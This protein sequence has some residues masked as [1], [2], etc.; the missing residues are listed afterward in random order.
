MKPSLKLYI[1]IS[2]ALALFVLSALFFAWS[3]GYMERAMIATSLIS[4]L[5][6]FSM[7]SAS[8]YMF[9]ISA[10][11]YGVEKEERGPS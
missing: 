2:V 5:I 8:L 6:G 7:L 11:V 4:A 1:Y 3:V 10:Y 9:R